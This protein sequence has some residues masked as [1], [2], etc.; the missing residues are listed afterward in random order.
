MLRFFRQ[1][2]QRLLTDN[3]FSKY[4]LYAV[5]EILLVVI[6]IL[7]ALQ[8]DNWNTGRLNARTE[9]KLLIDLKS[10][11][12][13]E[14]KNLSWLF[15][16]K[17]AAEFDLR[18]YLKRMRSGIDNKGA[19]ADMERPDV[20]GY[21]WNASFSILNSLLSSGKLDLIESDSLKY[22]L[23]G[24]NRH[25]TDYQE[26]QSKYIDRFESLYDL[27]AKYLSFSL[28]E[29]GDYIIKS[30]PYDSFVSKAA[31]IE[32]FSMPEY[33]NSMARTINTLHVQLIVA[34]RILD[35]SEKIRN[36]LKG[37]IESKIN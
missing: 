14:H 9:L 16:E 13:E 6:G 2:R 4:L 20:A 28:F 27:E 36:L 29:K 11:F 17:E 26:W 21:T 23:S 15:A 7:I 1:I 31:R 19:L 22:L 32:L 12:D 34:K 37:E 33:Q 5:G 24:W 10:E 25:I 30:R 8:V 35:N 3:K 18:A